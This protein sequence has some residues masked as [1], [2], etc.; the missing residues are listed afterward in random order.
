MSRVAFVDIDECLVDEYGNYNDNLIT[1]LQYYEEVWLMTGRTSTEMLSWKLNANYKNRL[2][3]NVIAKLKERGINVSGISLPYDHV[4]KIKPGNGYANSR[5]KKAEQEINNDTE[6]KF[7]PALRQCLDQDVSLNLTMAEDT[8]KSGQSLHLFNHLTFNPLTNKHDKKINVTFF[9]DK[10]ENLESV[11]QALHPNCT[12]FTSEQINISFDIAEWFLR[13]NKNK[14]PSPAEINKFKNDI[15]HLNQEEKAILLHTTMK[16]TKNVE[17]LLP[18]FHELGTDFGYIEQVPFQNTPLIWAIAN[19]NN[20]AALEFLKFA[21]AKNIDFGI[22]QQSYLG[23]TAL[24]LATAKDYI[25]KSFHLD[26]VE[27]NLNIVKELIR[28]GANPN[29]IDNNGYTALDLAAL[30]SNEG[31]MVEILKSRAITKDT[32]TNTLELIKSANYTHEFAS[33]TIHKISGEAFRP[34][35]SK[36]IF[37]QNKSGLEGLLTAKLVEMEDEIVLNQPR[38]SLANSAIENFRASPPPNRQPLRPSVPITQPLPP[39]QPPATARQT[40]SSFISTPV[41]FSEQPQKFLPVQQSEEYSL[42]PLEPSFDRASSTPAAQALPKPIISPQPL[43]QNLPPQ[44][45]KKV[46]AEEAEIAEAKAT[47]QKIMDW[48]LDKTAKVKIPTQAVNKWINIP[49]EKQYQARDEARAEEKAAK[50]QAEKAA[51]RPNTTVRPATMSQTGLAAPSQLPK[52]ST[53]R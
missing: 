19:A 15:Q 45:E 41:I 34:I 23:D 49:I 5:L 43:P 29:I 50:I 44:T 1:R 39:Q 12:K 22:N 47:R 2:I 52:I 21:E 20:K 9:D 25:D 6:D 35:P 48:Y 14:K 30:R 42:P 4:H 24:H 26:A 17:G 38:D 27:S 11:K 37:V 51:A 13:K 10:L 40:N 32:I 53:T 8:T 3:C 7:I 31:M 36:D 28:L 16:S 33:Q 46:T 18:V